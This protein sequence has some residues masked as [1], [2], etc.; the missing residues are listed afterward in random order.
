MKTT[1]IIILLTFGMKGQ[2]I[3]EKF[4]DDKVLHFYGSV[5]I[6]ESTYQIQSFAFPKSKEVNKV[7][8]SNGVTLACIFAKE[9]YDTKKAKPTGFS[10]DDIFVGSWAIPVYDIFNICRNDWKK[11]GDYSFVNKDLLVP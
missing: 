2:T 9:F 8:I 6:N 3:Q 11:R 7:L 4:K 5:L 1:L 10:W